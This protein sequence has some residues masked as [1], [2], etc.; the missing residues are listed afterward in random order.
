[1]S[2]MDEIVEG[3]ILELRRGTLVL[4]VMSQL[5]QPEYGYSLSNKL[6]EKGLTIDQNT[7]YPLLRRLEK[8]KLLESKWQLED[9]R[10]R[11]YYQLSDLGIQ[12]LST[13]TAEWKRMDETLERL[14]KEE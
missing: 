2:E 6:N 4:S 5:K 11:R 13:L 1:M 3:L 8:Q 14:L 7:L 9:S 10:Q 12:V